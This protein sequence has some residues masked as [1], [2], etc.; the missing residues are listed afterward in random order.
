[1]TTTCEDL[2]SLIWVM[3]LSS[4]GFAAVW[5]RLSGLDSCVFCGFSGYFGLLRFV[6]FDGCFGLLGFAVSVDVW[7]SEFCGLRLC[8]TPEFLTASAVWSPEFFAVYDCLGL[9]S[10]C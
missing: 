8:W 3:T 4:C 7:A 2:L 6:C 1:M 10:L 9:P 5:V